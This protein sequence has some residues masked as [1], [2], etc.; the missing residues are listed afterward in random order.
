[1]AWFD[2]P[3]LIRLSEF[4]QDDIV[5]LSFLFLSL[6][7]GHQDMVTLCNLEYCT[8]FEHDHSYY[9]CVLFRSI[10]TVRLQPRLESRVI[11]DQ[12]SPYDGVRQLSLSAIRVFETQ[13]ETTKKDMYSSVRH[14]TVFN[15]LILYNMLHESTTHYG[16]PL[17]FLKSS[18]QGDSDRLLHM[19]PLTIWNG[20]NYVG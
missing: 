19:S 1:M 16:L 8:A 6:T 18:T 4:S 20:S 13:I 2:I 9:T 15:R 14:L 3:N 17:Q 10:T 5:M 12:A 7:L 11:C